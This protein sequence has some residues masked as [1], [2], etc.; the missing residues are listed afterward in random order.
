MGS[1]NLFR[2]KSSWVVGGVGIA[3]KFQCLTIANM[4]IKETSRMFW[5]LELLESS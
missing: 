5:N 1:A 2:S 3:S 4:A